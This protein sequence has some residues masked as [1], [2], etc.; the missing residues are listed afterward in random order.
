MPRQWGPE[1]P[2]SQRE[3]KSISSIFG[4]TFPFQVFIN[5]YTIG[6]LS[7]QSKVKRLRKYAEPYAF[8]GAWET[9]VWV[10]DPPWRK[11][12]VTSTEFQ[13]R[14]E[15]ALLSGMWDTA[16]YQLQELPACISF[17]FH[18][19]WCQIC[20]LNLATVDVFT[21]WKWTNATTQNTS[22]WESVVK[23]QHTQAAFKK[24]NGK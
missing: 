11:A 7:S 16:F 6:G 15:R 24:A 12:L 4:A 2:G 3:G 18:V 9:K 21:L 10:E 1:G 20:S 5:L 22:H 8:S 23:H 13:L 14:P 19:Q 17:Q